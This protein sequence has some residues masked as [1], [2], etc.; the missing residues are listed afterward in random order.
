M[1]TGIWKA[2]RGLAAGSDT[3]GNTHLIGRVNGGKQLG[4][5][6]D[7]SN[8]KEATE[9]QTGFDRRGSVASLVQQQHKSVSIA[10]IT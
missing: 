6:T 2:K 10:N 3:T 4:R 5:L 8:G 9:K 7:S 1:G